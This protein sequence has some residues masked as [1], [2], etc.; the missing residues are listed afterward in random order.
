MS[1]CPLTCSAITRVPAEQLAA[2]TAPRRERTRLMIDR[3]ICCDATV[4]HI[5]MPECE[6]LFFVETTAGK[7]ALD[8]DPRSGDEQN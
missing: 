4:K 7:A 3:Q 2:F 1:T 6:M 5:D 8:P